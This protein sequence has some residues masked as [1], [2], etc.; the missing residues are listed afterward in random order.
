MS[1]SKHAAAIPEKGLA[2]LERVHA[3][4]PGGQ[5][6]YRKPPGELVVS[7]A[8]AETVIASNI[9]AGI[10][11]AF[12]DFYNNVPALVEM[13]RHYAPPT[14]TSEKPGEPGWYWVVYEDAETPGPFVVRIT[15]D[16]WGL[17]V[18][19]YKG[20]TV[21][22]EAVCRTAEWSGPIPTPPHSEAR[23]EPK[24]AALEKEPEHE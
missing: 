11:L 24:D 14:F 9:P 22:M 16:T 12:C 20:A 2:E 13:A 10:A 6:C 3:Q 8:G 23:D 17:A 5:W 1:E 4:L 19:G 7:A 18:T 21:P 15:R